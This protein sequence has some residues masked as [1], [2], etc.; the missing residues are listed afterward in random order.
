MKSPV[1]HAANFD[2]TTNTNGYQLAPRGMGCRLL[3]LVSQHDIA[4][5]LNLYNK[6]NLLSGGSSSGELIYQNII[7]WQ[8]A[9]SLYENFSDRG[10]FFEDGIYVYIGALGNHPSGISTQSFGLRITY[11]GAQS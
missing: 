10:L 5:S 9:H 4:V 1:V 6:I 8:S 11:E 7:H 3:S 2:T